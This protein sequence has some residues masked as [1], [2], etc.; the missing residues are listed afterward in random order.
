MRSA[1]GEPG[2]QTS[3]GFL[4][5]AAKQPG[6]IDPPCPP[7]RRIRRQGRGEDQ[8]N[9]R[10]GEDWR[11]KTID[12]EQHPPDE[13]CCNK[14]SSEASGCAKTRQ[15]RSFGQDEIANIGTLAPS[16]SVSVAAAVKI[17]A[18]ARPR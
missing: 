1:G 9:S 6:R 14:C 7:S 3:S 2:L 4:S 17:L 5:L 8:Q 13:P 10:A 15:T 16:A 11:I 18:L 12:L